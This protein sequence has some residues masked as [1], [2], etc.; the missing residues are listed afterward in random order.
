MVVDPLPT[1]IA[2]SK[3]GLR[4]TDKTTYDEHDP[5]SHE[6]AV[7]FHIGR[8]HAIVPGFQAIANKRDGGF[9]PISLHGDR[10]FL[11]YRNSLHR[12]DQRIPTLA[13]I[14][15]QSALSIYR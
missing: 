15:R 7:C 10:H 8:S 6:L 9:R 13:R 4:P 5:N 1:I 3:T 12:P 11:P 2:K 14:F